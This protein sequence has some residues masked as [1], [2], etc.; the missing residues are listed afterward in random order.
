MYA[1]LLPSSRHIFRI[2][3]HCF[4]LFCALVSPWIALA[5]GG[6]LR[7][8][9]DYSVTYALIGFV[10]TLGVVAFFHLG[11][12]VPEYFCR[13]DLV[14]VLRVATISIVITLIILVIMFGAARFNNV[15]CLLPANHLVFLV[16]SMGGWRWFKC[17]L[18]R[19][20]EL[21]DSALPKQQ[22]EHVLFVGANR[23]VG[24]YSGLVEAT[25]FGRQ[26]IV[27]ILDEDPKLWGRSIYGYRV[28]GPIG[29]FGAIVDEYAVHG[30]SIRRVMVAARSDAISLSSWIHFERTCAMREIK[31]NVLAEQ[32]SLFDE[33]IGEAAKWDAESALAAEF[34][35]IRARPY[36][37]VKRAFD[38]AFACSLLIALAPLFLLTIV[39]V[40]IDIGLPT[41]FWQQRVG[42]DRKPILVYK[43]RTLRPPFLRDGTPVPEASRVTR[44][45]RFLRAT[46]LD[47]LPQLFSVAR[48]EMSI[49]GPR[50]LLPVDLPQSA[51]LRLSIKPGIT[52]WAQVHGGNLITALEKNELDEWYVRNASIWLDIKILAKTFVTFVRGDR[53]VESMYSIAR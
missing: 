19:G 20:R 38:L 4:D 45:G 28:I 42:R 6:P 3:F 53:R 9:A 27:A 43:F 29:D 48:G 15:S 41:V 37:R 46:R 5:L 25:M 40:M 39:A 32:L 49:I 44:M 36:W 22:V 14:A 1:S 35:I 7:F 18:A 10:A 12:E 13:R 50:P 2:Y 21:R 24:L 34:A 33:G 51:E 26:K 17:R 16:G 47:E 52:G 11:Q 8:S 23:S 31:L 30:I